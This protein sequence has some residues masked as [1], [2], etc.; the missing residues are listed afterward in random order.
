MTA[1]EPVTRP[2]CVEITQNG[3]LIFFPPYY[4]IQTA[5]ATEPV[6]Q[7]VKQIKEIPLQPETLRRKNVSTLEGKTRH[8]TYYTRSQ[9]L[10]KQNTQ[11]I[12]SD[13][14]VYVENCNPA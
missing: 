4:A 7:S 13:L 2:V 14:T 9:C 12:I 1:V 3:R 5:S 8:Q 10:Q 11:Y 6:I